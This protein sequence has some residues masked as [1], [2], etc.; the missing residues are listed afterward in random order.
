MCARNL[1]AV[2]RMRI[3]HIISQ[4]RDS[5]TVSAVACLPHNPYL[6][7]RHVQSACAS[8]AMADGGA[9]MQGML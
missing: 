8:P 2:R 7:W 5:N 1:T 4:N 9:G 6:A 3:W